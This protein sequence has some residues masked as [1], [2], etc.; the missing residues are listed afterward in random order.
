MVIGPVFV[1]NFP[2]IKTGGRLA[3]D[4]LLRERAGNGEPQFADNINIS[5]L[6]KSSQYQD[7]FLLF[8]F[9]KIKC[10]NNKS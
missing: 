2:E 7:I 4:P 1:K 8:P 5:M 9:F 3:D 6:I 10:Y